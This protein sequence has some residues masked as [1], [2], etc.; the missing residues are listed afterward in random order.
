MRT[1]Q[2]TVDKP[3][4][5]IQMCFFYIEF[6]WQ[7]GS[8]N[9]HIR[10]MATTMIKVIEIIPSVCVGGGGVYGASVQPAQR[11]NN[12]HIVYF[13]CCESKAAINKRVHCFPKQTHG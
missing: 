12:I 13:N 9:E 11:L 3:P 10:L 5:R 7:R 2:H 6:C 1:H 4:Q 8:N